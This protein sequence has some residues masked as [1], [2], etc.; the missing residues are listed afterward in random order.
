MGKTTFSGLQIR[1]YMI[2][3][4]ILY[5][6]NELNCKAKKRYFLSYFQSQKFKM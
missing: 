4:E 2:F 1:N 6:I 5:F 3:Q